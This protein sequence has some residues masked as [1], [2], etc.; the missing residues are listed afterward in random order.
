MAEERLQKI[1]S[2][3]GLASRRQA[4]QWISEGR[5]RVDGRIVR[6]LGTRVDARQSRIVVDGKP[7]HP[8]R[9]LLYFMLHKPR[10]CVTTVS[11]PE[12]RPTV[13][14]FLEAVPERVYPVGRL[15]YASEGLLLVTNDGDFAN[16]VLSASSGIPKTYW[17]KVAGKPEAR[18]LE[19]LRE[20]IV[21]DGRKTLP[22]SIRPLPSPGGRKSENCWYEVILREGRQ[23][24]IRRMFLRIGHPV[25]KLKRVRIGK[26]T[27]GDLK[28]GELRPLRTA[29]V[30]TLRENS[31][32][33]ADIQ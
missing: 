33:N 15:D 29:E 19:M 21:L 32:S 5:V 10:G 6:E 27:L 4:E 20:G 26:L 30:R 2:R 8:A 25:R 7:L 1:I 14:K 17:V 13:M 16:H 12:G 9:R 31:A 22:A 11:D 3:A 24:Q 28:P 23:N 18:E